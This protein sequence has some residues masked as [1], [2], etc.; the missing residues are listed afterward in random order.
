MPRHLENT[1]NPAQYS[2][3]EVTSGD[4]LKHHYR[5]RYR[6]FCKEKGFE[7]PAQAPDGLERDSYDS[8]ATPFLVRR[9]R[10]EGEP[11]YPATV[12]WL[13]GRI[14]PLP[15]EAI[16]QASFPLD[17]HGDYTAE[18]SR[19]IIRDSCLQERF[20]IFR[21]LAR[22]FYHYSRARDTR[23]LLLLIQPALLR[24]LH[25]R[26]VHAKP[27]STPVQFRGTRIPCYIDLAMHGGRWA[28]DAETP[29]CE[30]K[31]HQ[32]ALSPPSGVRPKFNETCSK[33][34]QP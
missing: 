19:F 34:V 22:H 28:G 3:V 6:V 13:P 11:D 32:A 31:L 1:M 10:P 15:I 12:R 33:D 4:Q 18:L 26:D 17:P 29:R 20:N 23:Y 16:C 2:V 30:P 14:K 24:I 5:L 27:F 7:P 21:A 9:H 25:Y 8:V